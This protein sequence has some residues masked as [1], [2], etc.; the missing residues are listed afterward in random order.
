MQSK[1]DPR[2]LLVGMQTGAVTM[3][4]SMEVPQ[5]IKNRTTL[6]SS[7]STTGY[8]PKE[9]RN[10]NSKR[11][12]HPYVYCT[13]FTIPKLWKQLKCPSMDEDV[14]YKYTIEY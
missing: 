12:M 3:E 11:C 4:N 14:V 2:A 10:M 9:Y 8:L 5:K 6:V 13:L 1:R 7:N